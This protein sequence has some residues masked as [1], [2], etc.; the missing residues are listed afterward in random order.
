MTPAK[1]LVAP[2][3]AAG[4]AVPAHGVTAEGTGGVAAAQ[5][6]LNTDPHL[7]VVLLEKRK[8]KRKGIEKKRLRVMELG[9]FNH[10][11]APGILWD[12][13]KHSSQSSS[14]TWHFR[15]DCGSGDT[16]SGPHT[17]PGIRGS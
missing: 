3:A 2:G 13:C 6:T 10:W 7:K 4:I 12:R 14:G 11:S 16:R 8:K 5:R 17:G 9:F 15:T 1:A